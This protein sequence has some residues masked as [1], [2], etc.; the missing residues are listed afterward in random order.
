MHGGCAWLTRG[1]TFFSGFFRP[2]SQT[3]LADTS[4]DPT[5]LTLQAV[6][7]VVEEQGAPQAP[8]RQP[9]TQNPYLPMSSFSLE[10]NTTQPQSRAWLGPAGTQAGGGGEGSACNAAPEA[11]AGEPTPSYKSRGFVLLFSKPLALVLH[12]RCG[13]W[14]K[15]RWYLRH[16]F[17]ARS[18]RANPSA[19]VMPWTS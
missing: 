4:L 7:Q 3:A 10:P 16:S 15:S 11:A 19:G 8:G 13:E 5:V 9:F 6:E 17:W 14:W 1:A 12:R 2:V 18:R